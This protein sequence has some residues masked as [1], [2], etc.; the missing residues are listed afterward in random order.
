[1]YLMINLKTNNR[2]FQGWFEAKF[3][4]QNRERENDK[5]LLRI[6]GDFMELR[7]FGLTDTFCRLQHLCLTIYL[8]SKQP[9][10]LALK[11]K[12]VFQTQYSLLDSWH[13]KIPYR[14]RVELWLGEV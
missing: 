14:Q 9:H 12:I 11:E 5:K 2:C 10:P 1:M 3:F 13:E 7:S 8:V 6:Y 4:R